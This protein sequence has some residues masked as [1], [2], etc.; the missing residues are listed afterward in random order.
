MKLLIN[1]LGGGFARDFGC[2]IKKLTSVLIRTLTHIEADIG[3]DEIRRK[4]NGR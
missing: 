1:K 2:R 3:Y 4:E